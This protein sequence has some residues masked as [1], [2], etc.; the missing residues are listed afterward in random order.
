MCAS[1]GNRNLPDKHS[2]NQENFCSLEQLSEKAARQRD[3]DTNTQKPVSIQAA[4]HIHIR[5]LEDRR[6]TQPLLSQA[7]H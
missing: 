5:T 6:I 3:G 7:S 1:A 4:R 2:T